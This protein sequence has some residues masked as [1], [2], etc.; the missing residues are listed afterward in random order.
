[1]KEAADLP[2]PGCSGLTY[3]CVTAAGANA[4]S[5]ARW[6]SPTRCAGSS[7]RSASPPSR[8]R[9]GASRPP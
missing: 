1:M 5:W 6:S 4:G 3:S 7:P 9:G 8:R 2:A